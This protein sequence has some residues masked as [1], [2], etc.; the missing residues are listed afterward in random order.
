MGQPQPQPGGCSKVMIDED[1]AQVFQE[2]LRFVSLDRNLNKQWNLLVVS[3]MLG[4][5]D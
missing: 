5:V 2:R 3:N 1:E 4:M